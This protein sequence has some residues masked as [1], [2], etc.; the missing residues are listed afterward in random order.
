MAPEARHA[1]STRSLVIGALLVIAVCW[2]VAYGELV[3]SRGGSIYAI[4]LGA[5]HLPAGALGVL[6]V[7]LIL[8]AVLTRVIPATRL[9]PREIVTVYSMMCI[10]AILS[11]FGLTAQLLPNLIGC[12]YFATPVNKWAGTFYSHIPKWLVPFDPHGGEN[13]PV[14]RMFYEGVGYEPLPWR[15]WLTPLIAWSIAALLLFT[16]MLCLVSLLRRQWVDNEKLTFPL[17]QLPLEMIQEST[18]G[19][20]FRSRQMWIGFAVPAIVHT[21]NG[22]RQHY[23]LIPDIPIIWNL[24]RYLPGKPWT[25]MTVI[26]VTFA[27]SVIGISFLLPRDVCF[28]IPFFLLFS[29]LQEVIASLL[30]R[31]LD[32]MPVYPAKFFVGYQS[33]GASAALAVILLYLA[34]PYLRPIFTAAVAGRRAPADATGDPVGRTE[35]LTYPQA[36]WGAAIAFLGL[37]TWATFAGMNWFV[38]AALIGSFVLFVMLVL[39]RCVGEVGLLMLQPL[40]RPIDVLAVFTTRK[41]LGA[42][43]LTILNFLD[44]IFFRDP[45]G[46]MPIFMDGLKMA[47]TVS[48]RRRSMLPAFG[49]AALLGMMTAYFVQLRVIYHRGGLQ[50][51]SWFFMANPILYVRESA[52]RLASPAQ[53]DIRAPVFFSIG[54]AATVLMY[55]MRTRFLWWPF[56][57][58]GYA[59]GAAWPGIV[60]WW[61]FFVG[62]ALKSLV[63][64]YGSR[65]AY[66]R[67]R[68]LFLGLILGE[69]S[70]ALV[71]VVVSAVTGKPGPSIPLT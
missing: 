4:L 62:W 38:A 17:V 51:N 6:L 58:I 68:P 22:L 32:G 46:L 33:V 50:L 29:R 36:F 35:L 60:Y 55:F 42:A 39:A 34:R 7:V 43:N 12:N 45:R 66:R 26:F 28:S 48:L 20:F 56:H 44:G 67:A 59:I 70:T 27:F 8:R 49:I 57:P 16:L 21:V 61:S 18:A 71:W 19:P 37:V 3:V 30:G 24:N 9:Q 52:G 65:D 53:F 63:M 25:D 14:S 54:F 13:Q 40:F 5:T 41:S 23:P 47:D 64:H 69:Y 11:S 10:A 31:Q 1:V 15:A 2:V